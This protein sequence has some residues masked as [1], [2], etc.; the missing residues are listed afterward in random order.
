[1]TCII[2]CIDIRDYHSTVKKKLSLISVSAEMTVSQV[3]NVRLFYRLFSLSI[4]SVFSTWDLL[5]FKF[6][7]FFQNLSIMLLI[8]TFLVARI[9]GE[10]LSCNG[11]GIQA[12][13]NRC[14]S[15]LICDRGS[16]IVQSCGPETVF[17]KVSVI[18]TEVP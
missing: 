9:S 15:F 18:N 7:F 16:G 6:Y 8:A 5:F 17:H 4:F 11:S 13:A 12:I 2:Y 1:M 10:T 3:H 14:T